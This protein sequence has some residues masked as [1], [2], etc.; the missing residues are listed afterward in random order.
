M[1]KIPTLFVRDPQNMSRVTE[2]VTPGCE[3]VLAGEGVPTEKRDGTACLVK[4][5]KLWKRYEVKAGRPTPPDFLPAQ[6]AR[7]DT[8]GT[9]GWLPVGDGNDDQW[10]REAWANINAGTSNG[11]TVVDGTFELL[12]PKVQGNPHGLPGHVLERHG[13]VKIDG[14]S[15]VTFETVH[16]YLQSR[17]DSGRPIEGIVWH[18][19]DGRMAKI[20]SRDFGL[21]WPPKRT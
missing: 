3:W 12:G 16:Q 11:L 13:F 2:Q 20:K 4:D 8:G 10:H 5:N 21:R 14:P 1:R 9:P 15:P 7:E 17:H 18:H 6:E 19:P